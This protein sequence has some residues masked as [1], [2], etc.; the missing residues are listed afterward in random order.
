M[1]MGYSSQLPSPLLSASTHESA[2]SSF[3]D[4]K[5]FAGDL[6]RIRGN[7]AISVPIAG[8]IRDVNF[9]FCQTGWI[10]NSLETQEQE[11]AAA[12]QFYREF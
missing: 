6:N 3:P 10:W 2:E 7:S 12:Q 8:R 11:F 1:V 5:V 4:L 9:K